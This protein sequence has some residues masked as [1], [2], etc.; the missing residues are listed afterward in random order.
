MHFFAAAI[1]LADSRKRD[2]IKRETLIL[3]L[4]SLL[5]SPLFF[6]PIVTSILH[7]SIG[8]RDGEREGKQDI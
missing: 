5:F 7:G 2:G 4:P 3:F 8:G 1:H 6:I